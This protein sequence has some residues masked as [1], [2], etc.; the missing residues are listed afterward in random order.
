MAEEKSF[1]PTKRRLEKARRAGQTAKSALV[2]Q[3]LALAAGL[4]GLVAWVTWTWVSH[5]RVVRYCLERGFETP[6]FCFK[7]AG[8]ACLT[9]SLVCLGF[10]A[11]GAL[12]AEALQVGLVFEPSLVFPDSQRLSPSSGIKKMAAGL[13][14]FWLGLLKLVVLG[15]VFLWFCTYILLNVV[16]GVFILPVEVELWVWQ[17]VLKLFMG[18]ALLVMGCLSAIDY[19]FKRRKFIRSVSMSAEELKREYK[20]DEGDPMLR[21]FRR[22][23][24]ENLVMQDLIARVR[25]SKV[26]IVDKE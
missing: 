2:T 9:V 7:A 16:P 4:G 18:G 20:E 1:K 23:W 12:F 22:A 5:E 11:G 24:H 3:T 15:A 25:S 19:F 6:L 17:R 14:G 13:A 8:E 21:A 10:A 26:I